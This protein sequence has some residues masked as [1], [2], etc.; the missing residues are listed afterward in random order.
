MEL[1][2]L[3][4][5][6]GDKGALLIG[7]SIIGALFG[8]FAQQSRFCLRAAAI[9]FSRGRVGGKMAVWLIVF[10]T[11]IAGTM[12]LAELGLFSATETRQLAS[13][14][15]LSGAALGGLLFGVGMVLAAG[16][17]GHRKPA[18]PAL[19]AGLRRGRP[20]QPARLSLAGARCAGSPPDNPVDRIE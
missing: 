11:A 12:I 13:P 9:E 1:E 3:A 20:G 4:D 7:G 2:W 14:Q 16:A 8:A 6:F 5:R 18:R 10:S 15:S 19:G 17:F